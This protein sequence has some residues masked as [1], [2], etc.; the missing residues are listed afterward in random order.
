MQE[1][2]LFNKPKS[3]FNMDETGL[4]NNHPVQVI[5]EKG[6]KSVMSVTSGKKGETIS[7]STC[8]NPEGLCL[9]SA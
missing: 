7:I 9:Q 1:N 6:S 8:C 5:A 4:L 2:E 3:L